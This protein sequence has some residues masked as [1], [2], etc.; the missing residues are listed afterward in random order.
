MLDF[1][2]DY[3]GGI[4]RKHELIRKEVMA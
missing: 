4:E 3:R 1:L 2:A